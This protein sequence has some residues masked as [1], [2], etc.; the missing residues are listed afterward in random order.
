MQLAILHHHLNRGGVTS[1][2]Q[3][4]LR[5]LNAALPTVKRVKVAVLF[6][7]RRDAWS[8][9]I[10]DDLPNIELKLKIVP[11][12]DYDDVRPSEGG[13]LNR[14]LRAA[15]NDLGFTP[16]ETVL[17]VHNH[18]LGKNLELHDALLDLAEDG[19]RMLLQIHDFAEDMRPENYQRLTAEHGDDLATKLYPAA[20]HL[21]YAVLN[22][23][24]RTV[25]CDGVVNPNR[26]HF[27]PNPVVPF[28]ELPPAD[29]S[30]EK[31]NAV[32][33]LSNDTRWTVFPVRGI[34]RK[35]VGEMLL[36]AAV[37][38]GNQMFGITLPPENPAESKSYRHWQS[39]SEELRLSCR[40]DLGDRTNGLRFLEILSAADAAIT[41][42]VAEG[43]GMVFLETWLAGNPLCGRD[44]PEITA[45]FKAD[46]MT[47]PHLQSRFAIPVDLVG[48]EEFRRRFRS[49]FDEVQESYSLNSES[50]DEAIDELIIDGAVDFACLDSELQTRVLRAAAGDAGVRESIRSLNPVLQTVPTADESVMRSNADVVLDA[51]SPEQCGRRLLAAYKEVLNASVRFEH[52]S[53]G[54]AGRILQHFLRVDRFHPIRCE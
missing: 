29:A 36:W 42:S 12:L 54:D 28:P 33:S 38:E 13:G 22:G 44:L 46:G 30:R 53:T 39:L 43:F 26:V 40:F 25:L 48:E 23:R 24:D 31:L 2:I 21:H 19:Y 20:E 5:S 15:L 41:T 8:D 10:S 32:Y 1:V 37:A 34:R 45:D 47:F 7:G 49:A 50:V 16:D 18:S 4:H 9:E 27:L 11:E 51:Y 35:N 52:D 14:Q 3:N 6:G 17:H